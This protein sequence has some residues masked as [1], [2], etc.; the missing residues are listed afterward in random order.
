MDDGGDHDAVYKAIGEGVCS[1]DDGLYLSNCKLCGDLKGK[2]E[3]DCLKAGGLRC[4]QPLDRP[5]HK[6]FLR[7]P[8]TRGISD[9]I[10][11]YGGDCTN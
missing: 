7:T 3:A 6:S 10:I 9:F 11:C 2:F 4:Y 5:P 8:Q 1:F